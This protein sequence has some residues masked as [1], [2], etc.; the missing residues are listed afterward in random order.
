MPPKKKPVVVLVPLNQAMEMYH[1]RFAEI[2][3]GESEANTR[4]AER[5]SGSLQSA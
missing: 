1:R 5:S 2:S 4:R 3:T